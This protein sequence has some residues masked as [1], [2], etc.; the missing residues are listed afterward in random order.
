MCVCGSVFLLSANTIYKS[1]PKVT[2]HFKEY[3]VTSDHYYEV[4]KKIEFF[5][6]MASDS[7]QKKTKGYFP[8]NLWSLYTVRTTRSVILSRTW[9]IGVINLQRKS[10][11]MRLKPRIS[12][13]Y[14]WLRYKLWLS[15]YRSNSPEI[16]NSDRCDWFIWGWFWFICFLDQ[17]EK[18][19]TAKQANHMLFILLSLTVTLKA[20]LEKPILSLF[21]Y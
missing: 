15:D 3:I 7:E 5:L 21:M 11:V 2:L 8:F 6:L 9:R 19:E 4:G 14:G 13:S 18:G 16:L 20:Q 17:N 12:Q 1:G 10:S